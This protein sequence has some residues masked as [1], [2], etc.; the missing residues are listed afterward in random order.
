MAEIF[1]MEVY[2]CVIVKSGGVV[3]M[4][5]CIAIALSLIMLLSVFQVAVLAD[6][7]ANGATGGS[8]APSDLSSILTS[9]DSGSYDNYLNANSGIPAAKE[10]IFVPAGS[11]ISAEDAVVTQ[12]GEYIDENGTVKNGV[13]K[14]EK[15]KG[16]LTYTVNVPT[17]GMYEIMLEYCTIKGRGLPLAV[18]YKIDGQQPY[19]QLAVTNYSRVWIDSNPEGVV[20]SSGNKYASQQ[21]EKFVFTSEKA[22]DKAG[23]YVKPLKIALTAGTHNITISVTSGEFYF[24]GMTLCAPVETASYADVKADYEKNGYKYY[25]GNE[26]I[27]EGEEASYKSDATMTPLID[28]SDPSVYPS[29]PFKEVTNFI[30]STGWKSPNDTITW[31][32]NAPEDGLYKVGMRFRQNQVINGNSYRSLKIDGKSPFKEA[33]EISFYYS[34]SWQFQTLQANGEDAYVYLTKGPHE[35]SLTVTLARFGEISREINNVTFE[36]GNL[37]LKIRMITGET[38]DSGRRYDF[39]EQIAGFNDTLKK[40]I[41]DLYAICDQITEVTGEDSGTYISTIKNMIRVMQDMYDNPYTSQRY[42]SDYYDNYCSICALVSD[43]A[44]LPLDIDQIVLAS[45]EKK[46]EKTLSNWWEKTKFGF[47]RFLVSFMNDYRYTTESKN[48]KKTLTLWVTWG[49]DQTQILTSLVRD[50]FEAENPDVH[51]NIQIVGATLIQAILSGSGPDILLGQPR[52]EPVN[53]GMRGALYDLKQFPDYEEV[54]TR[55]QDGALIPYTLGDKVYGLPDTQTFNIMY[56]RTDIFE[57]MG[58][59]VPKTWDEFRDTTAILQRQNLAVALPGAGA[60]Q[61][62]ATFL[63]QSGLSLYTPDLKATAFTGGKAVERFVYW[64]DFYTN[65]GYETAFSFYNRFRAGT[66]PLGVGPYSDYVLFSQAAPEITGKWAIAPLPGTVREDGTIDNSQAD[67]GTS[68][69]IPNISSDYELSWKFL[70]WWTSDNIQYRY[71]TMVE[72]VLGE[73]GRVMT[74]NKEAFQM[75]SWESNDLDIMMETWNNV[76]GLEE[77]PGGYYVTRSTYQAFWNVVNMSKNPKDMI[78][79]WGKI[80]DAE[81]TR[82]RGEYNLD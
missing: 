22:M 6:D 14:W 73:V 33:E 79:K 74:A 36:I 19:A 52:T 3:H 12:M 21:I 44:K 78:V 59:T 82:K 56:Y 55:F 60:L 49:I 15:E 41:D 63:K 71:S 45:P 77:V 54:I 65:L 57:Q 27:I 2:F 69:V 35:L 61:Y 72:A 68:C 80:A 62:Y 75:L 29:A 8:S 16:S 39:F 47:K 46:F 50:S 76:E 9:N 5:K 37:Y 10:D 25:A 18:G 7:G 38:I 32:F 48:G 20:D 4:K 66:M 23:Q 40:C 17:D 42:V 70:K 13:V 81:I 31:T 26:I 51:V 30:G 34:G 11:Y 64:T 67:A 1:K 28:N 43:I 24:V 58:L 53:Y